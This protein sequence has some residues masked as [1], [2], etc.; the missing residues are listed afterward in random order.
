MKTTIN[1]GA[2]SNFESLKRI[3]YSFQVLMVGIAIPV[4][5]FIGISNSAQR[6]TTDAEINKGTNNTEVN[7]KPLALITTA[8]I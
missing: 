7:M 5:F 3:L 1:K 8:K 6:K 2:T 4:L